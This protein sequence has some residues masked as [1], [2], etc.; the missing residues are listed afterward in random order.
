MKRV[1][2][3]LLGTLVCF[4]ATAADDGSASDESKNI[5]RAGLKMRVYYVDRTK[6]IEQCVSAVGEPDAPML[7]KV[8]DNWRGRNERVFQMVQAVQLDAF[9]THPKELQEVKRMLQQAD[10]KRRAGITEATASISKEELRSRC[11]NFPAPV[12]S[13]NM[14]VQHLYSGE[15]DLISAKY[16]AIELRANCE[17]QGR[18]ASNLAH[19][20]NVK[21]PRGQPITHTLDW[22]H[23]LGNKEESPDDVKPTKSLTAEMLTPIVDKLSAHPEW[24]QRYAH[25]YAFWRCVLV[26]TRNDGGSQ[27]ERLSDIVSAC[28]KENAEGRGPCVYDGVTKLAAN[29]KP[30]TGWEHV[31][32]PSNEGRM[33]ITYRIPKSAVGDAANQ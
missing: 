20:I 9:L 22:L 17:L 18:A 33:L 14:D 5:A 19:E 16:S 1:C 31:E 10:D 12:N 28:A 26:E 13:G 6:Q 24:N 8:L 11:L 7:Q 27:D 2:V 15:Y 21:D 30:K 29:L 23:E 3:I 25:K 4:P 32:L